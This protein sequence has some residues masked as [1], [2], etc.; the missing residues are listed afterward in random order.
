MLPKIAFEFDEPVVVHLRYAQ[1]MVI[2]S[3]FYA[4]WPGDTIQ[5]LFTAD[6]GVFYLA[7][8]AGSLLNARLRSRGVEPGQP[9]TLT[10]MRVP[11]PNSTRPVT[12]YIPRVCQ[13]LAAC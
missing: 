13:E 3:K 4:R 2:D 12:E 1:G 5:Y 7:D 6:E 10:Q 9:I 11:N 8:G